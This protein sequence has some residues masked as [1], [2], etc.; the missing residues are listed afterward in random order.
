MALVLLV[1][2]YLLGTIPFGLLLARRVGV[3]VRRAGSGNIGATNVARSAGVR[4]GLATLLADAVKGAL[5][6]L[7]ARALHLGDWIVPGAALAA[8]LGHVYPVTLRF[9]GGKGVATAL[10][11]IAVLAPSVALVAVTVF[12]LA[13]TLTRR[14]SAGSALAAIATPL[15]ASVLA[16]PRAETAVCAIMAGVILL[17]H[18]DNLV[19]LRHGMEPRF[20]LPKRQAPPGK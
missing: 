9:A 16:A 1:A 4:L 7:A 5:P 2:A 3:D 10:G 14:V 13:F 19:R 20:T 8:F 17:R 6:V 15:A 18:V 12:A 11:A